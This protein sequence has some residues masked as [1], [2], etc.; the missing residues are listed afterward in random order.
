MNMQDQLKNRR[1]YKVIGDT[2]QPARQPEM[3]ADTLD[4]IILAAGNAP[5]HYP[6]DRIHMQTMRSPVP[7]RCYKLDTTACQDLM[8]HLIESGDTTKVPNMLAAAQYLLQ[9]TWLPDPGTILGDTTSKE[10]PVFAGTLRNMEHIAAG[11]AFIQSVLLGAEQ[12]GF[13]TYWSSGGPLRGETVFSALEIPMG[14]LLLGSIFLFPN[15]P[16]NAEIKQGNLAGKRGGLS[17]WSAWR[18]IN[19]V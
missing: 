2:A 6:C 10:E 4:E 16:E 5:F 15:E 14:E 18:E 9:V 7:W 17:D 1:T 11:S 8:H 3:K 19:K 12:S 13:K